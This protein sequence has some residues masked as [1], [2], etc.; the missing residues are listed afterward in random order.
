MTSTERRGVSFSII[1]PTFNRPDRLRD[2]LESLTR[3]RYDGGRFE[4]LVVDDG[5]E[6]IRRVAEVV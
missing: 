6:S 2:C 3:L 1:I 4:V 5:S